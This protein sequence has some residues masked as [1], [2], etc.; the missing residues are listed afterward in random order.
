MK[1]K[2][3][4]GLAEIVTLGT[5][6][7]TVVACL[8]QLGLLGPTGVSTIALLNLQDILVGALICV[9]Y[10][11][12]G[13]ASFYI[14]KHVASRV[15]A[16]YAHLLY[17][18]AVGAVTPLILAVA[19]FAIGWVPVTVV[20]VLLVFCLTN[21][22]GLAFDRVRS[23]PVFL[24]IVLTAFLYAPFAIGFTYYSIAK[25]SIDEPDAEI[26]LIDGGIV[27]GRTLSITSSYAF[28]LRDGELDI[29]PLDR[30][31]KFSRMLSWAR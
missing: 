5:G 22:V 17:Y 2:T 6:A 10:V 13:A 27:S 31:Q 4:L 28:I 3:D 21:A 14:A 24:A 20:I 1:F 15:A 16:N 29:V 25:N 8:F 12:L 26:I 7:S 9:P 30:V 18:F 19:G 23:S 11:T